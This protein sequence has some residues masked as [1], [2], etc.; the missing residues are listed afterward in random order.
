MCPGEIQ[1]DRR[2]R[3]AR[4]LARDRWGCDILLSS[5][6]PAYGRWSGCP[7][8][9]EP[10]AAGPVGKRLRGVRPAG[11]WNR[12]GRRHA[13]RRPWGIADAWRRGA[14][15]RP[16]VEYPIGV[17]HLAPAALAGGV[18]CGAS[19]L[20]GASR[21]PPDQIAPRGRRAG[22]RCP[23]SG[24]PNCQRHA[25]RSFRRNERLMVARVASLCSLVNLWSR[26]LPLDVQSLDRPTLRP[27][28]KFGSLKFQ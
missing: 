23:T 1:W 13:E 10:G 22:W 17:L 5:T 19:T 6:F 24:A 7:P 18:Q 28:G 26:K 2:R 16:P 21:G 9:S 15:D 12:S 4:S 14:V 20:R 11:G 8:R 25:R 27:L 3:R